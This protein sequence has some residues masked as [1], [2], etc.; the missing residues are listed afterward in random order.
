ME[1]EH[2]ADSVAIV[3]ED[4]EEEKEGQGKKAEWQKRT[5][6]KAF[7]CQRLMQFNS[8]FPGIH[9]QCSEQGCCAQDIIRCSKTLAVRVL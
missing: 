6:H 3:E 2:Q 5:K 7:L 8:L 1:L 4:E 9:S